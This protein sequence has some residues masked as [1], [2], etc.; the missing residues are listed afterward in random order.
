M[1]K[2]GDK[3]M[4]VRFFNLVLFMVLVIFTSYLL[5]IDSDEVRVRAQGNHDPILSDPYVYIYDNEAVFGLTYTD[6]D[7]NQG[8]V[9][10]YIDDDAPVSMGTLGGDPSEGQNF[11]VYL[12]ELGIDDYTEFYFSADDGNGSFIYLY[13][14]FGDPF[15]VGDFEGWGE[16]PILSNPNVYFD[17]DWIFNVTYQ[18]ID[19]DE[20]TVWVYIN[21][22]Y[23]VEMVTT[24]PNPLTGQN[25]KARILE[26][27]VNASTRF[28]FEVEDFGGS[29]SYLY[30]QEGYPF[31]VNDFLESG[32]G[33]EGGNGIS[34]EGWANPEVIIAIIGLVA[35]GCGSG[36]ATYRRKKKRGRFSE[37]LEELDEI[38]RSFKTHP[39]KCETE[40]EKMK[41]VINEDLKGSVIDE[42]NYSILKGRIDELI[43]EI[44]S[45]SLQSQVQD[46][47]KD[48]EIRIKDML[49]DG[50]ITR[51]EYDKILPIIKGSD[52]ASA[53]KEKMQ[54]ELESWVKKDKK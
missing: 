46:L 4:K 5:G 29:Y 49:I 36:Y 20:G 45:E 48:I 16:P 43:T 39:H 40:L 19:G 47:P 24:D 30:D 38:Y 23:S 18:D 53:D 34:F 17:D 1:G 52:M 8:E 33:N 15:L 12:P 6:I 11:E 21:D 42:N 32:K 22:E 51:D 7:D 2:N 13:D 28:Y 26:T 27:E 37:L 9:L 44:R 35:L 14:D 3:A 31:L 50:K 10:L 25:F 54:K 41:A